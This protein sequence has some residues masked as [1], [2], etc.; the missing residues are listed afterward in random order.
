MAALCALSSTA[1]TAFAEKGDREKPINITAD[2]GFEDNKKQEAVF[3]GN[4]LLTQGTLRV[5]A[6]RIVVHRDKDGFDYATATGS[7]ARF[8]Q[9]RDSV[10]E[11]VEG[12][13]QRI[14]YDGKQEIV[15]FFDSARLTR[16]QDELTSNYIQYN[17]RTEAFQAFN[18]GQKEVTTGSEG[19]RVK[20]VIQPKSKG[21][22]KP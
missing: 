15:Q 4:V 20:A 19:N 21:Q 6:N 8:R 17:S 12:Y 2:R 11:Y 10:D 18:P 9:K 7:P 13:A 14:E 16:G 22:A 1:L 3:E 5:D